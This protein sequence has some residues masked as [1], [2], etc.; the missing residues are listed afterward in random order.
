MLIYPPVADLDVVV[1]NH[2]VTS[3]VCDPSVQVL[4]G[5]SIG[6]SYEGCAPFSCWYGLDE[7][8]F[9]LLISPCSWAIVLCSTAMSYSLDTRWLSYSETCIVRETLA[10][11]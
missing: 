6:V 5:F 3:L 2:V 4:I 9:R 11:V 10:S 1:G 7:F 8:F